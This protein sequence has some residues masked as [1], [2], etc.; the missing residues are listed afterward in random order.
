[1]EYHRRSKKRAGLFTEAHREPS[2]AHS[3]AH[4]PRDDSTSE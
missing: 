2:L 3:D 4:T 1:M